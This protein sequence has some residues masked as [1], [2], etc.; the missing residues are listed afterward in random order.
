MDP[1]DIVSLV[2][3]LNPANTPGRLSVI[4]R[5]GAKALRA[6]LPALI[7]AVERSGQVRCRAKGRWLAG[8]RAV[9]W[10]GGSPAA[11]RSGQVGV[12]EA[13]RGGARWGSGE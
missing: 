5:M 3:S 10:T 12:I 11:Q 2:A 4:V 8:L 7:E 9:P 6:K 1:N 13:A